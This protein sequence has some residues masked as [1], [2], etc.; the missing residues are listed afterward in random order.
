MEAPWEALAGAEV[1]DLAQPMRTGM[2]QS[3]NHVP[4]RMLLER[5]HGDVVRPDGGSAANEVIVTGGHVGTHVDA[6]AHVSQEGRLHG[7]RE[8]ASVQ[9]HHGFTELGID[10]FDP[11]VGRAVLLDVAAVHGVPV[12]PPGYEITPDD[13]DRA[14]GGLDPA[15]GEALLIGTGWSRHWG[16]RELFTGQTGGAPGPGAAA[17]RWLAE[18]RPRLVGGES[19]AFEHIA[20]GRGHATLPVHR[21]LLVEAGINIVETMRLWPLLDAGHR[22]VLLI[23]NP[24]PLVGATGAPVRP[25]AVALRRGV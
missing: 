6:L 10:A 4:F 17:G 23:V 18:R 11:Y 25:L 9:G 13:L 8:A 22:E 14:A 24:L 7:G 16:E 19:I 2:P 21:I 15:P 1:F 20:P 3:P 5:R 12:L